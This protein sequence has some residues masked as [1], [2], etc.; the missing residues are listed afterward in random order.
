M[1]PRNNRV[2]QDVVTRGEG[3]RGYYFT[4]VVSLLLLLLRSLRLPS[5]QTKPFPAVPFRINLYSG[6]QEESQQ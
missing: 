1:K 4:V 5:T 3:R 6:Q 2:G